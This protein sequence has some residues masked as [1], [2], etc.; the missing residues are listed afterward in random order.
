MLALMLCY[1][2][3]SHPTIRGFRDF[4]VA[5]ASSHLHKTSHK[6]ENGLRKFDFWGAA[7]LKEWTIMGCRP[8]VLIGRV[9]LERLDEIVSKL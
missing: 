4:L 3:C 7:L 2:S 1:R 9:I 5:K 6:R 8:F